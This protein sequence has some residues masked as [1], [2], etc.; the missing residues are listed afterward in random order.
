MTENTVNQNEAKPDEILS[1]K[2]IDRIRN[3]KTWLLKK[4]C[5]KDEQRYTNGLL[6][7][8]IAML[9]P[10]TRKQFDVLKSLLYQ[11][12]LKYRIELQIAEHGGFMGTVEMLSSIEGRIVQLKK[13]LGLI[14]GCKFRDQENNPRIS[15]G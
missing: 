4:V 9:Q 10:I 1:K 8:Y 3:R 6:R 15:A 2:D 5:N 11:E 14:N 13:S 12:V 7:E